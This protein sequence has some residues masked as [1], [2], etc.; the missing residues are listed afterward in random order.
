[1]AI[2][3]KIERIENGL[4]YG[5]LTWK[6][7]N[8]SSGAVSG[9][10]GKKQLPKGLYKAFR[11]KLLDKIGEPAYCDSINNC[12]FQVIDPQFSTERNNLG[13]HPDGNKSGTLGCIG[14][15][16]ANTKEWYDAF[17]SVDSGAF[18]YVEVI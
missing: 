4:A 15:L 11:S 12:W 6:D 10:Y 17:L 2:V 9:P 7:K 3:F 18:N 8:L 1:M 14:L 5:M 13:I 16:N